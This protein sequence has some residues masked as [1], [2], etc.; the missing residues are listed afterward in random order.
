MAD[1]VASLAGE[2]PPV[3]ADIFGSGRLVVDARCWLGESPVWDSGRGAVV[4]TDMT[5]C[6]LHQFDTG[7]GRHRTWHLP[8]GAGSLAVCASGRL[9]LALRT[10]VVL[11][12]RESG[13]LRPFAA[14][15]VDPRRAR[16][17]DGKVG[18]DGAF[19]VGSTEDGPDP[20]LAGGLLFRVTPDGG[21]ERRLSGLGSPNGLAW[22]RDGQTMFHSDT[23]GPWIDRYDF[24]PAT[25]AMASRVRVAAPDETEGTPD[26]AATD[27]EGGHWS[28]GYSAGVLNRFSPD[29]LLLGWGATP[30]PQPTMPC[31]GGADL[32][33]IYLTSARDDLEA[34]LLR[35]TPSAGGLFA[36]EAGIA[37]VAVPAFEDP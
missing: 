31:F 17:N 16:L 18:P 2:R 22:S 25:G 15:S 20:D 35:R 24:V 14:L 27:V 5:G 36:F 13:A 10:Q 3:A 8:E 4:W 37:G 28:S 6:R 1:D 12:D 19:W 23:A 30:V 7:S 9:L 32:R 34:A 11:F 33:T 29:G 21:V 26:G